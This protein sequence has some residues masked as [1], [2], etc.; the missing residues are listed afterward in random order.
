[1]RNIS[2]AA[3]AIGLAEVLTAG[4]WG[5][6]LRDPA[7]SSFNS[8]ETQLDRDSIQSV[9][10]VWLFKSG[11]LLAAAPT[12][13]DGVLYFGDWDGN[14]HAVRAADGAEL[15]SQF[16]GISAQPP[17]LGCQPATGVSSQAVV[18]GSSVYVGGGDAALYALDKTSGAQLFRVALADT[19][20]GAYIWSS[21]LYAGNTLYLGVASLGDCPLVRGQLVRVDLNNPQNPTSRYL[22]PEGE[23]GAGLWSTPAIDEATNTLYITTG[24]GDQD[25]DKGSFGGAMLA[26]DASTLEPLASFFLPADEQSDDFDWGSSPTLFPTSDGRRLVAAT[27]KDGILYALSR[28]DLSPVWKQTVAVPCICPECGCGSLSTPAF[29][30]TTLYV[31]AGVR[32]PNGDASGSVYAINPDTG[33]ILWEQDLDGTVIAPVTVANGLIYTSTTSGLKVFD[34]QTGEAVWDDG[35]YGLLYSQTI[36]QDGSIYNTYLDGSVVARSVMNASAG[37]SRPKSR[38]PAVRPR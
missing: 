12:L 19:N 29:D 21:I 22:V 30:G 13:S 15:W 7:H 17:E 11:G 6:Y 34:S 28:D 33:E 16:V 26:L 5:M 27:G 38:R 18:V 25:P 36:V 3:L 8:S 10:N 23:V 1:M 14:F 4:D 24:N 35:G 32:D 37:G 2:L 20:N 9:Q 31:G